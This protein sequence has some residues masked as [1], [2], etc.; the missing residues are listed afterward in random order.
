M[1]GEGGRGGGRS[2]AELHV[3]RALLVLAAAGR[4]RDSTAIGRGGATSAPEA[5]SPLVSIVSCCR[6][7]SILLSR[8]ARRASTSS[9]LKLDDEGGATAGTGA[10]AAWGLCC[11]HGRAD[12]SWPEERMGAAGC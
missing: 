8:A 3:D 10:A 6:S 1:G 2:E 4:Q 12:D 7:R 9:L 11:C 5:I